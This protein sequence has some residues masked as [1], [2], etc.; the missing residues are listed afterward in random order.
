MAGERI[1]IVEDHPVNARLFTAVLEA[2][3]Y[4][5]CCATD[6]DAALAALSSFQPQLILMDLNLPGMDGIELTR[7]LRAD[8]RTRNLVIV[9]VTAHAMRGDEEKARAAGCNGYISKPINAL[10]FSATVG[11]YLRREA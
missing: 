5:I 8:E 3:G 2:G 7:Q 10:T 9:A 11:G 4:Q 6:A 1:L